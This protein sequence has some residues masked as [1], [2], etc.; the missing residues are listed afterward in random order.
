MK[1]WNLPPLFLALMT[2]ACASTDGGDAK[3]AAAPTLEEVTAAMMKAGTPGAHHKALDPFVGSWT[4]KMT[5][6]MDPGQPP[7]ESTGSMVNSWMYDG[8]YLDQKFEGDFMGEPFHG[9]GMWG[10]DVAANQYIG[11]WYDSGS[12]SIANSTGPIPAD[13]KTFTMHSVMTDPMSG[14]P[15]TGDTVITL[16][17]PNQ[18]TM[19]MYEMRGGEKVKTMV[20]VYT[21]K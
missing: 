16:D 15:A 3:A 21:R 17:G 2:F 6:W 11:F 1:T 7:M 8:R 18:H 20:I 14:K 4:A 10:F 9:T 19:T 12:T 13:G 5:M